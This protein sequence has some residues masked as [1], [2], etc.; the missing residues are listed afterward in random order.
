MIAEYIEYFFKPFLQ[1]QITFELN[2]KSIKQGKLILF[3]VKDF[4]IFFNIETEQNRTKQFIIPLPY[5]LAVI[6]DNTIVLDYTIEKLSGGNRDLFFKLKTTSR[7]KQTRF[8]DT[9]V[10]CKK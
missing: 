5:E 7:K 6:D 1:S 8:F 9:K 4:H 3:D 2:N 10:Y